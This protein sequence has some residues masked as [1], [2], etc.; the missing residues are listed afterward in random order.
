M[1]LLMV[2]SLVKNTKNWKQFKALNW[3]SCLKG[4]SSPWQQPTYLFIKIAPLEKTFS[5][6]LPQ[7]INFEN[8]SH[9]KYLFKDTLLENIFL[10]MLPQKTYFQTCSL[11][12]CVLKSAHHKTKFSKLLQ[13]KKTNRKK[14]L[15]FLDK[16]QFYIMIIKCFFLIFNFFFYT[17]SVF[18]FHLLI[19]SVFSTTTLWIFSC[20]YLSRPFFCSLF[21]YLDNI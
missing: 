18:D 7:E 16:N 17:Q 5:K 21:S 12:K 4:S 1:L 8:W 2:K 14:K 3:C 20:F 19:N 13:K 6:S 10:K 11:K 15:N 9:K